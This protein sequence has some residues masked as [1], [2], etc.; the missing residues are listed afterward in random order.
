M[1]EV[2]AESSVHGS[3]ETPDTIGRSSAGEADPKAGARIWEEIEAEHSA[4]IRLLNQ[5]RSIAAQNQSSVSSVGA[6]YE[7]VVRSFEEHFANEERLMTNTRFPEFDGHHRH[8]QVLLIRLFSICERIKTQQ[9]VEADQLH[10]IL[11]SLLDDAI[12][13]DAPLREHLE[14]MP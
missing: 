13:A 1:S 3:A 5:A 4:I 10:L 8:H 12:G 14:T 9:S 11:Q 7:A 6:A 2:G